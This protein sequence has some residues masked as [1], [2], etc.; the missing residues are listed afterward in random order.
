MLPP[1][2]RYF[3]LLEIASVFLGTDRNERSGIYE[4]LRLVCKGL[5][6]TA[7]SEANVLL[8]QA[9][10]GPNLAMLYLIGTRSQIHAHLKVIDR[11]AQ[12]R[13]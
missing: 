3:G 10:D 2:R 7:I 4:T 11:R 9:P 1:C 5:W 8:I 13:S 6:F 12:N